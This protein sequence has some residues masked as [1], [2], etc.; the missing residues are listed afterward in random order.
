DGERADA[1]ADRNV[2]EAVVERGQRGVA[3]NQRRQRR[4]HQGEAAG[5]LMM[6]EGE[7]AFELAGNVE[8]ECH[9]SSEVRSL[10]STGAAP[11]R[12]AWCVTTALDAR[13]MRGIWPL[14]HGARGLAIAGRNA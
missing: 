8:T 6:H 4:G 9:G 11:S 7:R 1:D 2:E 14:W 13:R 12:L 5:R 3:R 10:A